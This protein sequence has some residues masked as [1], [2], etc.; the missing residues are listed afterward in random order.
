M[1]DDRNDLLAS[2]TGYARC[3]ICGS[4]M[5]DGWGHTCFTYPPK[6]SR[7]TAT[8]IYAICLDCGELY[9]IMKSHKCVKKSPNQGKIDELDVLLKDCFN[10]LDDIKKKNKQLERNIHELEELLGIE[11]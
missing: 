9:S 7:E 4:F 10:I 1:N 2:P 6:L 8:E 3:P 11:K 5:P